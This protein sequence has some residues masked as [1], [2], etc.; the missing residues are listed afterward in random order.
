MVKKHL[1]QPR[2]FI[3]VVILVIAF[4]GHFVPVDSSENNTGCPDA[5]ATYT[6]R[7]IKSQTS[8]FKDQKNGLKY[9]CGAGNKSDKYRLYLW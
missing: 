9:G 4:A 2:V 3:V 5:G 8:D 6:Y 7:V 1:K